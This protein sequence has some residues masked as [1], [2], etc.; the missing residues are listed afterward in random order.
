MIDAEK[1]AIIQNF[2]FANRMIRTAVPKGSY[3]K[4]GEKEV[5]QIF[6]HEITESEHAFLN[7]FFYFQ[8]FALKY[9]GGG[10]FPGI[11]YGGGVW[12]LLR[13][14]SA[15]AELAAWVNPVESLKVLSSNKSEVRE[16]TISWGFTIYL[17]YLS[18]AYTR[19][20]RHPQEVSRYVDV[21]FSKEQLVAEVRQ[22][23]D[24]LGASDHDRSKV[25]NI[26]TSTE[27][28]EEASRRIGY[29]LDWM[30]S[31]NNLEYS[32][33]GTYSQTIVGAAE[34]NE[35]FESGL[36]LLVPQEEGPISAEQVGQIIVSPE[37]QD[38]VGDE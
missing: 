24:D 9:F 7:D 16:K 14:G 27:K 34:V 2:L 13:S 21:V 23:I 8:G 20:G 22:F 11:P 36:F 10:E 5:A 4:H 12:C 38:S 3:F 28:G 26:L 29:F 30:V 6:R 17:H 19:L 32:K 37:L 33:D 18:L 1:L 15:E 31:I 35:N 25:V